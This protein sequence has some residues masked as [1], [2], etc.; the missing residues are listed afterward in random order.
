MKCV[1]YVIEVDGTDKTVARVALCPPNKQIP[2][3]AG[4]RVLL[5][6]GTQ[7]L[8]KNESIGIDVDVLRLALELE[9]QDVVF[10]VRDGSKLYHVS[11]DVLQGEL[12]EE[13]EGEQVH[14][15]VREAA[16]YS[17]VNA[18]TAIMNFPFPRKENFVHVKA[19]KT[20]TGA[21]RA[22]QQRIP[23]PPPKPEPQATPS[24]FDV[25]A[26]NKY[27]GD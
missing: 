5:T 8:H 23:Q 12:V 13:G 17:A 22:Q 24:L 27:G 7:V 2:H 4:R 15:P 18:Y 14:I 21:V 10:H 16:E 9:V 25:P 1:G 3:L 20:I 26:D 11:A 6:H 19:V